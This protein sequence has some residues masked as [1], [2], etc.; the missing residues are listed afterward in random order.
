MMGVTSFEEHVKTCK[1]CTKI[2]TQAY[3]HYM[4]S[5]GIKT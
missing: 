4:K 3:K 2:M 5:L 1:K